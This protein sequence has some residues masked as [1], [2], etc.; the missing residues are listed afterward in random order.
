MNT[1]I[2]KK[3]AILTSPLLISGCSVTQ[4]DFSNMIK[5]CEQHGGFKLYSL[6]PTDVYCNDGTVIKTL[7]KGDKRE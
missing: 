1:G 5:A 3:I 6:F 2:L 4:E 7:G